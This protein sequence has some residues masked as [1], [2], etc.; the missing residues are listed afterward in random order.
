M[1]NPDWVIDELL[2]VLEIYLKKGLLDRTHKDIIEVSEILNRLPI[3]NKISRDEKFRNEN[4]VSLKLSNFS[5][6]DPNYEGKGMS[7]GNKLEKVVWDEY[8][9]NLPKLSKIVDSIKDTVNNKKLL[10]EISNIDLDENYESK[11]GQTTIKMLHKYRERDPKLRKNKIK[12]VLKKTGKLDCEICNFNFKDKYG[13]IGDGFIECHH[14]VPLSSL[15]PE[16]VVTIKDLILLCS[17]C[18]RMIHRKKE[19]VPIDKIKSII[20]S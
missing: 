20:N 6:F 9:N 1:K 4:G 16:S 15:E 7:R 18:H 2:I 12:S 19:L 3:H 5:R 11:E 17:N 10:K 13:E 14:I 8:H